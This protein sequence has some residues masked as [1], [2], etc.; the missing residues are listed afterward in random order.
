[1]FN[2]RLREMRMKNR[3]TQQ[4][5][6]DKLNI[7]LRSYQCYETG[8]RSPSFDLLICIADI[9]NVS[10]DYLLG[11]DEFLKSLGVSVDEYQINPPSNPKE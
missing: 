4:N 3:F 11:R 8:T 7:A 5:M 1:M 10:T 6:A 2:K 9:L